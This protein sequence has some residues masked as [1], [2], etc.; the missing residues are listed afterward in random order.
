VVPRARN[1]RRVAPS[2]CRYSLAEAIIVIHVTKV[3]P[4]PGR[5]SKKYA[6]HRPPW[7]RLSQEVHSHFPPAMPEKLPNPTERAP[8]LRRLLQGHGYDVLNAQNGALA[9]EVLGR[10]DG[11]RVDLVLTDLRMPVM[12]GRQ[13]ASALARMR[14]RLPIILMSGYTAQLMDM[15]LVS[16]GLA[17]LPKPFRDDV[18]LAIIRSHLGQ[19]T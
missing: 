3:K 1:G 14:P 2:R 12:D 5:V 15:R 6:Y 8:L 17:F 4:F 9:L 19:T 11:S 18:L 10:P 7:T 16:P 13:L